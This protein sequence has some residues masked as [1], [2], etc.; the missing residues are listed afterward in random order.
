[1]KPKAVWAVG[2][3]AHHPELK[4]LDDVDNDVDV[5]E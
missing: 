3:I 1:V 4:D 2:T 5:V